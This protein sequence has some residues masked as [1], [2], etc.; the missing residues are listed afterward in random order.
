MNTTTTTTITVD[1]VERT[2]RHPE[3]IEVYVHNG[4]SYALCRD[5]GRGE[6]TRRGLKHSTRCDAPKGQADEVQAPKPAPVTAAPVTAAPV[7]ATA[8][9]AA[10][11]RAK[12]TGAVSTAIRDEADVVRAV[13][14]GFLSVSDAMNRD[15]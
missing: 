13:R 9:R 11:D 12:E 14:A 5:C 10:A 1:G 2:F 4:A 15:D 6:Y 3:T 8:L 7:D